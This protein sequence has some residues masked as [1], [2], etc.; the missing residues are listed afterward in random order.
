MQLTPL[1]VGTSV[2]RQRPPGHRAADDQSGGI[3]LVTTA[4]RDQVGDRRADAD[5]EIAGAGDPA[6]RDGDDPR[7]ERLAGADEPRDGRSG[8]HVLADDADGRRQ[9]VVRHLATGDRL[10]QLSFGAERIERRQ[11]DEFDA[12]VLRRGDCSCDRGDSLRLVVLDCDR[13][14]RCAAGSEHDLAAQHDV[15]R[16]FT[17]QRVV[18]ADPGLAL[19]AVQDQVRD[20]AR[21]RQRQLARRR[22]GRAAEARDAGAAQA[23]EQRDAVERAPVDWHQGRVPRVRRV[24]LDQ[25]ATTD[26]RDRRSRCDLDHDARDGRVQVGRRVAGGSSDR[27]ADADTRADRDD[28]FRRLAGTLVERE[29]GDPWRGRGAQRAAAAVAVLRASSRNPAGRAGRLLIAG[30]SAAGRNSMQ[31]TGQGGRQSSQ[32]VHCASMTVCMKR[33]APTMA[34]TGQAGRHSAQPMQRSSS[35]T[36]TWRGLVGPNCGSTGLGSRPSSAASART[37]ASPP[38]GQRSMSAVPL[39]I[40]SA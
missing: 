20:G 26:A 27:R 31:S 17:H 29:H 39:A 19:G 11:L 5:L 10:D 34:S 32:P 16:A 35:I 25:D 18:A 8:A 28:R 2:A 22:K 36:A 3:A 14:A 33:G 38:G 12:V 9:R 37:V 1:V 24:V 40:A 21:P 4:G 23:I 6:P 30:R 15:G 13:A 7:H